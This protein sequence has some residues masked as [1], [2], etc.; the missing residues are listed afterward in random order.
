MDIKSTKDKYYDITGK[1]MKDVYS[2]ILSEL[3]KT[4]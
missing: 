4:H 3:K 2:Y 1:V